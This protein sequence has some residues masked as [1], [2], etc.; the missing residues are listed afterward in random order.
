M[1]KKSSPT[2]QLQKSHEYLEK[3]FKVSSIDD[4][5]LFQLKNPLSSLTV[6]IPLRMDDGR[7]Q[8]FK[9]YRV[10]YNTSRGPSKGGIR[11]HPQVSLDEMQSLAFFMTLKCAVM[12]LPFGGAKGGIVVDPKL[13]S[14]MELE[15]LSRTYIQKIHDFIGPL[16]DIPAPDVYTNARIMGWMMDEYSK[17]KGEYCPD[18]ITG[19]PIALHGSLGREH[20][21]GRG[22]Y[23]CISELK[24]HKKW[25]NHNMRVAIQ[26][27]GNVGQA[28]AH[29]LFE[30]GYK[31]V[32]VSDS[33]GGIYRETGFDIPSLIK[34]KNETRKLKAVYCEGSVCEV[35]EASTISNQELLTLD[36]DL[37]IPAAL[38]NQIDKTLAPKVKAP[39][40][41][42]AANGPI[43]NEADNIL[44][45]KGVLIVPDIL[46][47]AGGVT[48]SYFEWVQNKTGVYWSLAEVNQRLMDLMLR[49]FNAVY[50]I[51]NDKNISMRTAAYVHALNRLGQSIEAQGTYA[52]FSN[53]EH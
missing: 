39:Y 31:I 30:D 19:K 46:A 35:V 15:R 52:Y 4:E 51:M 43:D 41:I 23:H 53:S 44:Y 18:V 38:E 20:A 33:K 21:T 16:R 45:E 34:S 36:V 3:A 12:D 2:S 28:L 27:F 10:H 47:N 50:N 7:L 8:L 42:E 6:T 26:G 9:A 32:A 5:A 29:S 1:A 25:H 11:Y 24:R 40:I 17:I 49:E 14:P 13:L 48:V 37:L 22:V